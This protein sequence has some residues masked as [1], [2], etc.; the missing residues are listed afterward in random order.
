MLPD[1]KAYELKEEIGRGG[2]ATV[3]LAWQPSLARPVALKVLPPYFAQDY[4]LLAR[5]KHEAHAV[6]QLRHPGIVAI[7]DFGQEGDCFYLAMEYLSGGSLQHKL[8]E[9]G[10]LPPAEAVA[11]ATQVAEGLHHAHE[12]G[13]VHRDIK[14]SNILL[15]ETGDAVIADFGIVKALRSAKLTR[16]AAA[17][18]GTSEYMSPEQSGGG[19]VDARSDLYSLGA[20]LYEALTG[21]VPFGGE[22]AA[23]VHSHMY[24][25]PAPPSRLNPEIEPPLEEVVL[26]LLAKKPSERFAGALELA[27]ALR[28]LDRPPSPAKTTLL[29]RDRLSAD[30]P[31]VSGHPP[32]VWAGDE[33]EEREAEATAEL[34]WVRYRLAVVAAVLMI[35]FASIGWLAGYGDLFGGGDP[36]AQVRE[37]DVAPQAPKTREPKTEPIALEPAPVALSIETTAT[38][39]TVGDS[40]VGRARFRYEDGSFGE[41]PVVWRLAAGEPF[42]VL[43]PDGRLTALAPGVVEVEAEAEAQGEATALTARVAIE[44]VPAQAPAESVEAP[45][46]PPKKRAAPAPV[47]PPPEP[48]PT[49]DRPQEPIPIVIN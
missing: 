21:S 29:R 48:A 17:G 33:S 7:Y 18:M 32:E 28:A 15:S 4:E 16:T 35:I 47:E 40:I 6:A 22:P 19:E 37:A 26:R 34:L 30:R 44:I 9:A 38:I 23:V 45:P 5:F 11:I 36:V 41:A 20:V 43:A 8:T 39:L 12:K 2:M 14:P 10:R 1:I 3:Y 46:P 13:F 25:P 31:P 42:A 24:D 27:E 49:D